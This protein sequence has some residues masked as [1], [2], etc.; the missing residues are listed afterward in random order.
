MSQVELLRRFN[1]LY[2][3][4][5]MLEMVQLKTGEAECRLRFNSGKVLKDDGTTIFS[6]E[7]K[8]EPASLWLYGVRSIECNGPYQLNSTVVDFGAKPNVEV[9]FIDFHF[10]L[11]G[12]TDPDA[13]LVKVKIVAKDFLFGPW[14]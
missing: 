6:P 7:S 5:S 3:G 12:G 8:F 14:T 11:T 4:D 2:L 13:F 9:G 1:S 10:D